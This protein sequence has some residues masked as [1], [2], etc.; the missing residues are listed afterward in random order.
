MK[1]TIP[2]GTEI[3]NFNGVNAYS[4]VPFQIEFGNVGKD[5][6]G[7]AV[8]SD[9]E[10]THDELAALFVAA[11]KESLLPLLDHEEEFGEGKA[12]KTITVVYTPQGN[13]VETP[14]IEEPEESKKP[15][16]K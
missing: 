2:G 13:R 15:K 1:I 16:S 6:N 12:K 11:G 4:T 8:W 9:A 3:F 14:K 7:K 5:E 10:L